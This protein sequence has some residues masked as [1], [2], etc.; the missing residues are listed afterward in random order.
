MRK[1]LI[2]LCIA[3]AGCGSK[4]ETEEEYVEEPPEAFACRV[5]DKY[6]YGRPV[7]Y[8]DMIEDSYYDTALF[9]GDS[10]MGSIALYG[11]HK[12]AEVAY[13]TSLNLMR[14]DQMAV[15]GR[16][17]GASLTD[18]LYS[19]DKDSV[20]LLFGINEIRNPNFDSFGDK[21]EEIVS[22]MRKNDPHIDIYLILSYHPDNITGLPEP[23]LT[24]HLNNLNGKI[25]EIAIRNKAYYV[26]PDEALDDAEGTVIDDYVWD[27]LHFNV[28]GARAFEDFLGTHVVRRKQ[29]VQK[30]CE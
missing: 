3:L 26:N 10:R 14:V 11:T 16:S 28:E 30:I 24:E 22:K 7:P 29:Y 5:I 18:V 17:D 6:D 19:T 9:A 25:R 2:V 4:K 1:W 21:L 15:D 20:Y 13:V 27:G 23:S 8:S 12:N